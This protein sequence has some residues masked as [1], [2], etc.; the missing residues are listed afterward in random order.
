MLKDLD[1]EVNSGQIV[2]LLGPNGAGKRRRWASSRVVR[3]NSGTV[4][5]A[6]RPSMASASTSARRGLTSS[7]GALRVSRLHGVGEHD[8]LRFKV[9][10]VRIQADADWTSWE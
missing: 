1:L 4:L 5:L 6:G 3:P 8:R 10:P 9:S 2:G 7:A